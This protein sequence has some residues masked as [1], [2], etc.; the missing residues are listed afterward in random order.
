VALSKQR[1]K[2]VIAIAVGVLKLAYGDVCRAAVAEERPGIFAGLPDSLTAQAKD[3]VIDP[4]V[5]RSRSVTV[6]WGAVD[7]GATS[8]KQAAGESGLTLNLFDDAI[9]RA[10]LDRREVRSKSVIWLGH[11]EG[12]DKSQV[13]LV[14]EDT[15]M[16]GNIRLPGAYFQV[17]YVGSGL[18]S[19]RQIDESQFPPEGQPIPMD[20]VHSL[21]AQDSGITATDNGSRFDVMVVYTPAARAAAG[22]TTAM[23]ALINLAVAETNTAYSRSGIIPRL[24]LV[25]QEEVSYTESG[26]FS[27]DLNR[28]TNP[29]DGFMDNVHALRNTYGADLVSL[30]I[31]GTSLCGLGW[32]MTTESNS[33]QALAFSVVARICATGNFSLGHEMGHNMGLQH[34]RTDT[35]ANGVFPFSHGYAD[36]PHGFRDIMGVADSCGGCMR[37]QNFSNPNVL[38]NGFPTGVAQPSPQSADAATS[39]NATA[40][41]VANWRSEV[42][43]AIVAAVLPS[44]R[45]VQAGTTAT[46]FATIINAGSVTATACG[47]SLLT[48]LPATFTYQTTDPATNQVIGSPNTPVN[49]AAGAAQSYVFALTPSAPVAPIDLQFGFDCTNAGPAPINT[50]LNTLLFSGST[51]PVPD[52][53]AL[54]ATLTNDGIVNIP[55]TNGTG[56]FAV[57]TVNVGATGPITASADTGATSLSFTVSLC[58]TDPTTGQC[59]SGIGSIVTTT[60]NANATP[61]FGIFVQGNGNVPFDP[62]ANRIFVRFKDGGNVTRGST[63]VAVRTQ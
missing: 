24:R 29:S 12:I 22:G 39:L 41:T 4:T 50:G 1:V 48:S 32:L 53:V 38:F 54:A 51:A 63:S 36:T 14:I 40:F 46:A 28:L 56:A 35:P 37:I 52:V 31:E 49:I 44:S 11:I 20:T 9:F 19:V 33:F 61:T 8:Q 21:T 59:I 43:G 60:I 3:Q 30:I 7:T 27:T 34:D 45:S 2:L 62:A 15:V 17:R 55:G 13:T 18:H 25:H 42:A 5:S 23:Q 26:D 10:V 16:A 47:I 58:E 57:A 6:N